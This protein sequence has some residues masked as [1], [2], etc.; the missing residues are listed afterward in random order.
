MVFPSDIAVDAP[1]TFLNMKGL[2]GLGTTIR[3]YINPNNGHILSVSL[4]YSKYIISFLFTFFQN[5]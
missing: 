4:T 1:L 3:S 2:M 5:E